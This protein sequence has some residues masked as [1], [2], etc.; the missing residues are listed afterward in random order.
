MNIYKI[1]FNEYTNSWQNVVSDKTY[2][3]IQCDKNGFFYVIGNSISCLEK[4]EGFG[5]G[6]KIVEVIATDC[7]IIDP[8]K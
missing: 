5:K 1:S 7:I 8:N 4:L 2:A 6:I 3:I